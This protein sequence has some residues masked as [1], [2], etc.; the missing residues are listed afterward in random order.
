M[1]ALVLLH[2]DP[3]LTLV[4]VQAGGSYLF[5][6]DIEDFLL[7]REFPLGSLRVNRATSKVAES[8]VDPVEE[9]VE[10]AEE[11]EEVEEEEEEVDRVN[12]VDRRIV[13][14]GQQC[15]VSGDIA[16]LLIDLMVTQMLGNVPQ[17]LIAQA[18]LLHVPSGDIVNRAVKELG[19]ELPVEEELKVELEG[20]KSWR[21]WSRRRRWKRWKSW[22]RWSRRRR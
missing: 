11:M 2:L 20:R 9:E 17:M 6:A 18:G 5:Q 1:R 19:L 15:S 14:S 22:R 12:A 16:R 3:C 13:P 10:E 21:R 8:H 4:V 7:I